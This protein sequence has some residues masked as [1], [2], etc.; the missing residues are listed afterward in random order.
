[1]LLERG[2]CRACRVKARMENAKT[3][4]VVSAECVDAECSMKR[5][6]HSEQADLQRR[7]ESE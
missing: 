7:T 1:M 6:R 3:G 4:K 2:T 5:V